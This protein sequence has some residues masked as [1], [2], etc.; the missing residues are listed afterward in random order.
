MANYRMNRINEEIQRELSEILRTV[1]DPR[2]SEHFITVT[3]CDVSADLKFAKIY[4]S[5]FDTDDEVQKEVADGI[6]SAKKYIRG[7]I[8]RRLNIR[9]TPELTFIYDDSIKKGIEMNEKIKR[10][11]M[12]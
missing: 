7:E 11:E 2:V 5:I 6:K 4:Y 12:N 3:H 9:Y 10:L 8:S 1:K